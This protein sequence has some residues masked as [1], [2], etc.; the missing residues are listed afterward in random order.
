M[1]DYYRSFFKSVRVFRGAEPP[2]NS[3]HRLVVA[4]AA[5]LRPYAA[6]TP[7]QQ[8]AR[9]TQLVAGKK[10]LVARN[11]LLVACCRSLIFMNFSK[12]PVQ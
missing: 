8:V 12:R 6:F 7:A 11:M 5:A 9:N 10:Q 4:T 3:D 1:C 2:A